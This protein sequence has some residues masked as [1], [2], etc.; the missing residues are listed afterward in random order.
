VA[1]A[2]PLPALF[3]Q[4][5]FSA[6]WWGQFVSL[7][8]ERCTYLALVALLAEHT[9]G[10]RDANSAWLLSLF[11]IVMLAPVL[12]FAPFAGAW[13]DRRDL[14][15]VVVTCDVLRGVIALLV[16]AVYRL[17][18]EIF[19]VF[20]LLFLLFTCGVIFLPAKSSLT[21]EIVSAPQLLAAN[22]WLTA[23]G[24]VAAGL[25]SLGGGWLVDHGGWALG[26]YLNGATY[27]ISAGAMFAIRYG[28]HARPQSRVMPGVRDYLRQLRD[29]W[30]AVRDTAAVGFVLTTLGIVWWCGGFLHVAGNLHVQHAASIPG[31]ERL[32]TL[33]AV[34][35]V[36][37]GL[38]AWWINVVAKRMPRSRPI[39]GAVIMSGAGLLLFAVST[40]FAMFTAAAFLMGIAATPILIVGETML[41]ESTAPG[42]RGR[43]FATRDFLMRSVL[44]V[45]VSVAG[46]V[47][48]A[49]GPQQALLLC[50]T[51][52]VGAGLLALVWARRSASISPAPRSAGSSP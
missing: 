38:S 41:Q 23:A 25:G 37:G 44:L 47:T 16:P 27:L 17:T 3:R 42:M 48:R 13:I 20:A 12:I 6:L 19:P 39:V 9:H 18:G 50:G 26:L 8:G 32:G 15:H 46:W 28:P 14:R 29:G 21:P 33:M 10:L 34:L 24:I 1:G 22:T 35:G 7:L 30:R 4:R 31:M 11:A 40:R 2:P 49:F 45:S 5:N 43:V 36:G 52:V 51:L